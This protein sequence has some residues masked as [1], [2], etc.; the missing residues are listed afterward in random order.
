MFPTL[1]ARGESFAVVAY[2]LHGCTLAEFLAL[3]DDPRMR[4]LEKRKRPAEC[5]MGRDSRLLSCA[6]V[7]PSSWFFRPLLLFSLLLFSL[8]AAAHVRCVFRRTIGA[9][10]LWLRWLISSAC[11]C[12]H[13]VLGDCEHSTS[14][15]G[16][17]R[18]V[19]P[20]LPLGER[21]ARGCGR[22]GAPTRHPGTH[23]W[24]AGS[25]PPGRCRRGVGDTSRL[26]R[27]GR[28]GP[29]RYGGDR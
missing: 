15:I 23:G 4:G 21:S 13:G 20:V 24:R 22:R 18:A 14:R 1:N 28:D 17:E 6:D 16:K 11:Q 5:D 25:R 2:P 7:G 12:A 9:C 10:E 19:G 27:R 3:Q 8:S 29:H 26:A